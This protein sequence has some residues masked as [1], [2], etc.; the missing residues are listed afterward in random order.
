MPHRPFSC[1][2]PAPDR[3]PPAARQTRRSSPALRPSCR[4]AYS[5]LRPT[6]SFF[7]SASSPAVQT[8]HHQHGLLCRTAISSSMAFKPTSRRV[9]TMT[10]VR[11]GTFAP[12]PNGTDAHH[13]NG[14]E[15]S[16]CAGA[17]VGIDWRAVIQV[18]CPSTTRMASGHEVLHLFAQA[19]RMNW[20]C[21]HRMPPLVR[22]ASSASRL[23]DFLRTQQSS[24]RPTRPG[25]RQAIAAARPCNHR[26]C[27]CRLTR[28]RGNLVGIDINARDGRIRAKTAEALHA[29]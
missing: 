28:R 16:L 11:A 10:A 12:R 14:P 2:V 6:F 9:P 5:E 3:S 8:D 20:R 7:G 21:I 18:S 26:R 19:Q 22:C 15:L 27:R 13:A 1:A 17:K 24:S 23:G 4:S 25:S 29:R